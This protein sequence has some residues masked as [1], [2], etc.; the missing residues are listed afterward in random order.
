MPKFER[1]QG[2]AEKQYI[3]DDYYNATIVDFKDITDRVARFADY[4]FEI[5]MNAE[6]VPF[7]LKTSVLIKFDR[8]SDGAL[9][10]NKNSWRHQFN[11]LLDTLNYDGGFDRYGTF[12]DET[13]EEIARE[14]IL[15]ELTKHLQATI[16]DG[17]YPFI[18]YVAKDAKGYKNPLKRIYRQKDKA[19]LESFVAY[20]ND[21]AKDTPS[22]P[23]S[24]GAPRL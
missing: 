21:K 2:N 23:Q 1:F 3:A 20:Y 18:I 11:N 16:K 12:R 15:I 8:E 24:S 13:G 22:K 9:D 17:E 19:E 7:E 6:K 4:A 10:P 5:I 14:D